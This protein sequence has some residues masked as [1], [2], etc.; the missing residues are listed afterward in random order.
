M[1]RGSLRVSVALLSLVSFASAQDT[2]FVF[3]WSGPRS[4]NYRTRNV[5]SPTISS[6][7]G[8]RA[9]V[10]V[11]STA[12]GR[13]CLNIT[14]LF[15]AGPTGDFRRVFEAE[16]NQADDGNGMRLIGWNRAGTKLLAELGRWTYGTDAGIARDVITSI[17]ARVRS[18]NSTLRKACGDTL[19]AVAPLN[20]RLK[21]GTSL[22]PSLSK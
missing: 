22:V 20:L 5:K 4:D 7:T 17:Q 9:Y 21:A 13:A 18:R 19:V 14:K 6:G 12:S 10:S 15:V 8:Q 2:I 3:C 11:K 1:F 16:P